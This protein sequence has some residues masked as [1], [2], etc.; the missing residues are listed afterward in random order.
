MV[1]GQR[2]EILILHNAKTTFRL[3]SS[4]VLRTFLLK[5]R[6]EQD[7]DVF[8]F[9]FEALISVG[10]IRWCWEVNVVMIDCKDIWFPEMDSIVYHYLLPLYIYHIPT[11]FSSRGLRKVRYFP[12]PDSSTTWS[13]HSFLSTTS[14][15]PSSPPYLIAQKLFRPL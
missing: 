11:T 7:T 5:V 1:K 2:N 6:W 13:S 8:F 3:F 15:M 12:S 9:L 14:R 4:E 10:C